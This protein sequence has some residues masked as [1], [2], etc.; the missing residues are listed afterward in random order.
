MEIFRFLLD[1]SLSWLDTF[2]LRTSIHDGVFETRYCKLMKNELW[3]NYLN[4]W[5]D[6][7]FELLIALNENLWRQITRELFVKFLF[8]YLFEGI[9]PENS[10]IHESELE[11]KYY[12]WLKTRIF[13]KCKGKISNASL[14]LLVHIDHLENRKR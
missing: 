4:H 3:M 12:K 14:F 7:L 13:E 2:S 11:N 8:W 9:E 1:T 6:S 10:V 5:F